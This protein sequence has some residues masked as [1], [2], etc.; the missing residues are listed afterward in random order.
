MPKTTLGYFSVLL[1]SALLA[2]CGGGGGSSPAV[3]APV[4]PTPPVTTPTQSVTISGDT[5]KVTLG[6]APLALTATTA[7][8]AT[9][10]WTLSEGPGALSASSGNTIN[11]IPPACCLD[12]NSNA[13]IVITAKA[14]DVSKVFSFWLYPQTGA[15][16]LSLIT[17][18]IG[19]AGN[20]DGKGDAAR[21]S[22][23]DSISADA[24]GN[25]MLID[26]LRNY[27]GASMPIG[28]RI[29]KVSASGEVST[30]LLVP[31][32]LG[33][34]TSISAAADGSTLLLLNTSNGL[35]IYKLLADGSTTLLL[36]PARTDQSTRRIVAGTGGAVYM[37]GYYHVSVARADGSGGILAG[38]PDDTTAACRDGAAGNARLNGLWDAVLDA[39]GNLLVADCYS[40]RK[41]TPAG[42]VTTLAGDLIDSGAARDGTGAAAHFPQSQRSLAIDKNG[43][44]LALDYDVPKLDASDN[45][46]PMT[47]RLRKISS[48]GV[49]TTLLTGSAAGGLDF[50][51]SFEQQL[52]PG[53]AGTYK[54]VRYLADGTAVVATPAQLY[55]LDGATLTQ[56]A[57][58]EGDLKAEVTGPAASARIVRPRALGVEANGTLHVR[59]AEHNHYKITPGGLVSKLFQTSGW[60][61]M[62]AQQI[63][64]NGGNMYLNHVTM[65]SSTDRFRN[66]GA[67][68]EHRRLIDNYQA[69]S[70]L[71]GS[72]QGM[73]YNA[74]RVDGP[75][76]DATFWKADLLGFD[77]D[78]NLYVEDEQDAKPLYRKITPEGVVSTVSVLPADL[79]A[80]RRGTGISSGN[81]LQDGSRYLYDMHTQLI[82]RVAPN[83]DKTVVAGS[84]ELFGNRLGA[85]PGSL[86]GAPIGG[87]VEPLVPLTL[88]SPDTYALISGAA[89]LK[90][91]V[92]H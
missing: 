57:G 60:N 2:A 24:A 52:I 43:E 87:V 92:P 70:V 80:E 76:K 86:A 63:M 36:P 75:G 10:N 19:S 65:Q 12:G 73:Q 53:A 47:Y 28:K 40:V 51:G 15:A 41:I 66:S 90:L 74:P 61:G 67:L 14:G 45:P 8:P 3:V 26:T 64:F 49:V 22:Q 50:R 82:Y 48:S 78:N 59:D 18:T 30:P 16:G 35:A 62:R 38:N 34:A 69:S 46:L 39:A 71:A 88:L 23:I 27:N 37:L 5:G 7:V 54:F 72:P 91:V 32:T 56:F 21:F 79:G 85:L 20:L 11:Y 25:L 9:V 1:L 84:P 55:K 42:I 6:S 68:I 44:L 77:N 29:R 58:N 81:K 13:L 17:G 31:S 4:T 89:V 83:G 33:D